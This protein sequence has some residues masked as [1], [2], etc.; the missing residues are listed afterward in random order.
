MW[1][2][3]IKDVD[4]YVSSCSQHSVTSVAQ[5][6]PCLNRHTN[7]ITIE[8]NSLPYGRYLIHKDPEDLY[9]IQLDIFS[10]KYE[11]AV[12][13]HETWGV[14]AVV[15]GQL[16]CEEWNKTR[17]R[18]FE[19]ISETFMVPG[20]SQSFC[21]PNSDWHKVRTVESKEQVVTIHVYG[22]GFNLDVGTYLD[23]NKV[24]LTAQRSDFKSL[25]EIE[26]FISHRA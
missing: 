5:L 17:E 15:K 24:E 16:V 20:C 21:P 9:N 4:E 12:H 3:L 23:D 22:K 10:E 18:S 11:G 1:D 25:N 7:R 26:T 6:L 19:K 14:L 13:S 8:N 2:E